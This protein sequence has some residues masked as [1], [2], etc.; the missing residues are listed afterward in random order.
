MLDNSFILGIHGVFIASIYSQFHAVG[1]EVTVIRD[2]SLSD[3][4]SLF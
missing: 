2:D 3:S 1:C 4:I